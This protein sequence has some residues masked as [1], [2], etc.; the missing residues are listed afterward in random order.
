MRSM[1][2]ISVAVMATLSVT[3]SAIAQDVV[4]ALRAHYAFNGNLVDESPA[5]NTAIAVGAAAFADDRFGAPH[6]SLDLNV[7]NYVIVPGHVVHNLS[8][9]T[10]N[11]WI[12]VNNPTTRE[13]CGRTDLPDVTPFHCQYNIFGMS[14]SSVPP[15][16][17][18]LNQF[19]GFDQPLDSLYFLVAGE[20]SG[21][22]F[23]P[24][25][26]AYDFTTWHMLTF[27][28]DNTAKR[29]FI[30]GV[31]QREVS[32]TYTTASTGD[33]HL[34]RHGCDCY[35][36]RE[37]LNGQIDE[38]R[39]YGRA[40]S[41]ADI[42]A[43][44]AACTDQDA[45][46]AC[47]P[48]DCNDLDASIFP[49]ATDLPGNFVDENCDGSLGQCNPCGDWR[50]HGDYVRC[51]AHASEALV[52]EGSIGQEAADALVSTA[53]TSGIGKRGFRPPECSLE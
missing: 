9:G 27:T 2:S 47:T 17:S 3:Q 8:A 1:I 46:G 42:G 15:L 22:S 32:G 7:N 6:A 4:T 34:G 36:E 24:S 44:H 48:A 30:D 25:N 37:H 38:L 50:N 14:H 53:A 26:P 49:G 29:I 39:I 51:V 19:T 12:R 33:V 43:L 18:Q 28:W 35:Q 21:P 52:V 20:D 23:V 11:L 31:L 16:R 45:D 10:I 41:A 40:L 5:A 13:L